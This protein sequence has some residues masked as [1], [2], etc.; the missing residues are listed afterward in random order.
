MTVRL[1]SVLLCIPVFIVNCEKNM[2]RGK[3]ATWEAS[4]CLQGDVEVLPAAPRKWLS[5]ASSGNS[6]CHTVAL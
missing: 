3:T 6:V 2:A 1:I 4:P 5:T